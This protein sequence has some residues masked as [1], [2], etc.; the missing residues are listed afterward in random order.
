MLSCFSMFTMLNLC[1]YVTKTFVGKLEREKKARK[2]AEL[3][4]QELEKRLQDL[5]EEAR[6]ANEARVQTQKMMD[7]LNEKVKVAEEEAQAHARKNFEATEEIRRVKLINRPRQRHRYGLKW[8]GRWC[9]RRLL[10]MV[11]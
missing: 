3:R 1:R 8:A 10:A 5:E 6:R 2:E 4:Q 7:L 9:I 11:L